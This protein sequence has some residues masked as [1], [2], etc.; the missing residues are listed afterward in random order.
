MRESCASAPGYAGGDLRF[1]ALTT[2]KGCRL[3]ADAPT[4]V[5]VRSRVGV[6]GGYVS[7]APTRKPSKQSKN[8]RRKRARYGR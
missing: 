8:A 5:N 1:T 2:T 6:T 3:S 4:I 7:D